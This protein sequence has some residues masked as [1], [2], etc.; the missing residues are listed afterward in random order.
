MQ[1]PF[2]DTAVEDDKKTLDDGSMT[3]DGNPLDNTG[4]VS[5]RAKT[6]AHY[7]SPLVGVMSPTATAAT[8][9]PTRESAPTNT[10][11]LVVVVRV[12]V[13]ITVLRRPCNDIL[14]ARVDYEVA[15]WWCGRH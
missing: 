6:V 2:T 4:S 15:S 8:L 7:I 11:Q 10:E 3:K 14:L 5:H 1:V 12:G 9:A 13:P